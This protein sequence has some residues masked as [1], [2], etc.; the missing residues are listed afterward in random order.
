[1]R[2]RICICRATCAVQHGEL[3]FIVGEDL[4][5]EAL[6]IC[7]RDLVCRSSATYSACVL[8]S[9]SDPYRLC[10]GSCVQ[11]A[12]FQLSKRKSLSCKLSKKRRGLQGGLRVHRCTEEMKP[13]FGNGYSCSEVLTKRSAHKKMHKGGGGAL[14]GHGSLKLHFVLFLIPDIREGSCSFHEGSQGSCSFH[15][16][17]KGHPSVQE[18]KGSRVM[19]FSPRLAHPKRAV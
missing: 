14:S 16:G 4:S 18:S 7:R 9:S 17:S 5:P 6:H 1:V 10:A 2:V 8:S 13:P 15:Q 19:H 12:S 11:Y 3:P